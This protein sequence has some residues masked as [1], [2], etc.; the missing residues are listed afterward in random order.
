[1]AGHHV[2]S[3]RTY[4]VIFLALAVLT[5]VTVQAAGRDF[6]AFNTVIALGIAAVKAT[7][8]ILFFMHVRYSPRLTTLVLFSGFVFLAIL[9]LITFADY[10]S[11]PWPI[12]PVG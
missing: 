10:L 11:R 8:V 5:V 12:T 9:I 2:V 1:M 4:L 3:W 6:G 7:L